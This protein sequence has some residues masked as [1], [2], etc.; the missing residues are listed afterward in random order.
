MVTD[1][2]NRDG[3]TAQTGTGADKLAAQPGTEADDCIDGEKS[4]EK[5]IKALLNYK[6]GVRER[7]KTIVHEDDD[8]NYQVEGVIVT[9]DDLDYP[10][11]DGEEEEKAD[12]EKTQ[13]DDEQL[14]Q[15]QEHQE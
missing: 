14:S 9:E 8:E 4:P 5:T 12:L 6:S 7:V 15:A 3:E 2:D 10:R 11:V 13:K 1:C